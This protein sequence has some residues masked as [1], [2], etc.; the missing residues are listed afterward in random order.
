MGDGPRLESVPGSD[1]APACVLSL[2]LRQRLAPPGPNYRYVQRAAPA[3]NHR[4]DHSAD[5]N[6]I[7]GTAADDRVRLYKGDRRPLVV[8][9]A[10]LDGRDSEDGLRRYAW[11]ADRRTHNT[12]RPPD[13]GERVCNKYRASHSAGASSNPRGF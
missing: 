2:H 13:S 10:G 11:I 12:T 1:P 5:R 6:A 9:S 3:G 7:C 8:A 4:I